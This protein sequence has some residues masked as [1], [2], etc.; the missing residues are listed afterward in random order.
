MRGLLCKFYIE[1]TRS[2]NITNNKEAPKFLLALCS[3]TAVTQSTRWRLVQFIHVKPTAVTNCDVPRPVTA[4]F[5]PMKTYFG[6]HSTL[7]YCWMTCRKPAWRMRAAVKYSHARGRHLITCVSSK[8]V[9]AL[10]QN[11]IAFS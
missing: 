7:G 5:A 6:A 2:E 10:L 8:P 3:V 11:V 1:S 9:P 4:C